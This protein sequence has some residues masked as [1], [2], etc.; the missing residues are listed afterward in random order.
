[1]SPSAEPT[2][3]I[4]VDDDVSSSTTQPFV[5]AVSVMGSVLLVGVCAFLF[6]KRHELRVKDVHSKFFKVAP[7]NNNPQMWLDEAPD[8]VVLPGSGE[9]GAEMEPER[10]SFFSGV[11]AYVTGR[12]FSRSS[13]HG[14]F[15][16]PEDNSPRGVALS[17]NNRSV[18]S[19][20]LRSTSE[21]TIPRMNST[22]PRL[23]FPSYSFS[24]RATPMSMLDVLRD[25]SPSSESED[26][27]SSDRTSTSSSEDSS[28]GFS[29]YMLSDRSSPRTSMQSSFDA[30]ST[31]IRSRGSSFHT[32]GL[33]SRNTSFHASTVGFHGDSARNGG[34]SFHAAR[35][36]FASSFDSVYEEIMRTNG[37][38]AV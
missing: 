25:D 19:D 16:P 15:Q 12:A 11:G 20:V 23:R 1:V 13:S 32:G 6:Y 7:T 14:T 29:S 28:G 10:R 4:G 18:S 22:S 31:G 37:E 30:T 2:V 35:R 36:R 27:E 5:V 8:V 38:D 33:R 24:D 3:H 17:S 26:E 34:S 9:K 21:D